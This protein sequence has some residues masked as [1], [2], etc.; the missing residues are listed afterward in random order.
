MFCTAI[1]QLYCTDTVILLL[2]I[3]IPFFPDSSAPATAILYYLLNLYT[4][5]THTT[6]SL[7]LL[8]SRCAVASFR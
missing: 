6:Q 5:S 1:K 2:L 4:Y 3:H 7:L 8:L